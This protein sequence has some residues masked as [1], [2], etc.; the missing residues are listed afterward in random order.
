MKAGSQSLTKRKLRASNRSN[1]DDM[2][3]AEAR[4]RRM[5][6]KAQQRVVAE[7]LL[8]RG[9]ELMRGFP[10]LLAVGHGRRR[11]GRRSKDGKGRIVQREWCV[12]FLVNQKWRGAEAE[13]TEHRLPPRLLCFETIR[14]RRQLLAVPTDVDEMSAPMSQAGATGI[15]SVTSGLPP[16]T[17][18]LT[19]LVQCR[20]ADGRRAWRALSCRHVLGKTNIQA[21]GVDGAEVRYEGTLI[22]RTSSIRGDVAPDQPACFDAQAMEVHDLATT[23]SAMWTWKWPRGHVAYAGE[24]DKQLWLYLP[25]KPIPVPATYRGVW[26]HYGIGY[27]PPNLRFVSLV[28]PLVEVELKSGARTE[29]GDS[30]S[31]LVIGY[32]QPQ[33]AGMHI[34]GS[35][36]PAVKRFISFCIPAYALLD[37]SLYA[38]ADGETWSLP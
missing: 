12:L 26:S 4:F 1:L 9:P 8:T 7:I 37:S 3:K 24:L 33:L 6:Q 30:G 29:F 32:S 2:A 17:G 10:D 36:D 28:G 22:G 15:V 35:F 27:G 38:G 14:G 11:R 34:A 21:G 23:K 13:Q 16:A 31:P 19:C 25:S 20:S 5:S 18:A